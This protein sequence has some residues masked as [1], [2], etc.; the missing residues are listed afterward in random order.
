MVSVA[1]AALVAPSV[2]VPSG[3][4][5]VPRTAAFSLA[6]GAPI[7]GFCASWAPAAAPTCASASSCAAPAV[8]SA[9]AGIVA[10]GTLRVVA[11]SLTGETSPVTSA[12]YT[13]LAAPAFSPTPP[14][15]GAVVFPA[16]LVLASAGAPANTYL[17]YRSAFLAGGGAAPAPECA[18]ATTCAAGGTAVVSGGAV[19]LAAPDTL[20]AVVCDQ[21]GVKSQ[22]LVSAT[23][24][25]LAAPVLSPAPTSGGF[26]FPVTATATSAGASVICRSAAPTAPV[27]GAV[28]TCATGTAMAS[29]ATFSVA[30]AGTWLLVA[31]DALTSG[32]A[33]TSAAFEALPAP[34]LSLSAA[35]PVV[36]PKTVTFS[37]ASAGGGFCSSS[38]STAPQC[39]GAGLTCAVGTPGASAL[40]TASSTLYVVACTGNGVSTTPVVSATYTALAAPT[41]SVPGGVVT[42]PLSVTLTAASA[43]SICVS[44]GAGAPAPACLGAFACA[45]GTAT[46]SGSSV[47]VSGATSVSAVSCDAHGDSTVASVVSYSVRCCCRCI[48]VV[49]LLLLFVYVFFFFFFLFNETIVLSRPF[50]VRIAVI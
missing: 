39:S 28:G 36:L 35:A 42:F 27:C 31:C 6:G 10:A 3:A 16:S 4:I 44:F 2:S 24:T 50:C 15:G 45:A 30:A 7:G 19:A 11:C 8:F 29:G 40:V 12:A 17:C 47:L 14:G 25:A 18:S 9:S 46:S 37:A 23:F 49:V 41:F 34:T 26:V 13:L 38:V 22:P 5:N 43:S 32:T 48:V 33:V 1:I 20:N 21:G